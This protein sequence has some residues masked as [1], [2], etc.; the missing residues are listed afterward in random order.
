MKRVVWFLSKKGNSKKNKY[1]RYFTHN[2]IHSTSDNY[3]AF[4]KKLQNSSIDIEEKEELLQSFEQLHSDY[5]KMEFLHK[6][7]TKDKAM[8][9][10]LLQN[11]VKELH[12]QKENIA[13]ANELLIQQK[14][15]IKEQSEELSR[16][17]Y[18][19]QMSY[20]ELEQFAYIA[21]HDLKSPLRNIGSYAQL[22]KRR[23]ADKLDAEADT[24]LDFISTN[25]QRMNKVISHLLEYSTIDCEREWSFTDLN[26]IMELIQFNMRDI[27]ENNDAY[28]EFDGLPK[29]WIQKSSITQLLQHIIENAI[30]YRTD[31]RPHI[32]ISVEKNDDAD[33]WQ[34]SI[35]DNGLGLDEI[36]SEKVFQPF[37]RINMQNQPGDGMGLAICRKIVKLYG[38]EIW[39]KQNSANPN[40]GNGTTFFFTIPQF[41]LEKSSIQEYVLA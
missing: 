3:V 37:Q 35:R 9:I 5:A 41:N 40:D 26:R 7:N 28:I 8:T 17:L 15:Q 16:S 39:Y 21:S 38:G 2:M 20:Q 22:L 13:N 18:A 27:I 34:F 32:N 30:K 14:S 11:S 23:Y 36:Y 19:L 31:K 25:A 12:V 4:K 29:I 33:S 10:K 24:F 6:Q 1:F